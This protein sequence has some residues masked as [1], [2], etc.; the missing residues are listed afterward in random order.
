[1][2]NRQTAAN[3]SMTIVRFFHLPVKDE[4]ATKAAGRPI[5]EDKE[6]CE[7]RFAGN[8]EKVG[9]FPAHEVFKT[10]RDMEGNMTEITYALEY[11]EQYLKFKAGNAQTIS[12]TPLDELPFLSESKRRELKALNISTAEALAAVDGNNL[13]ML[14]MGG[15]ELK[16]QAQAYLDKAA[17]SVDLIKMAARMAELEAQNKQLL[18]RS[19]GGAVPLDDA[20]DESLVGGPED[21]NASPFFTMGAE[22]IR[23]WLEAAGE[24]VDKRLGHATLVKRADEV[25]ARI[26][27]KRESVAA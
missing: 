4:A 15:R 27:A 25:N 5:F 1:M 7:I 10:D 24:T 23:N 12:G 22:D 3:E 19:V 11:N 18:A 2:S 26:K 6:V 9:H 20:A 17:G 13:K 16:N 21:P 14:G 8:R